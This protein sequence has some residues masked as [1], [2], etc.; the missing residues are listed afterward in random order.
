MSIRAGRFV[1]NGF[2]RCIFFCITTTLL[3]ACAD[4]PAK[5]T[6]SA[7]PA[8]AEKIQPF[9]VSSITP[10]S[11]A[12][13]EVLERI[14]EIQLL[15]GAESGKVLPELDRLEEIVK[16]DPSRREEYK[17]ILFYDL[18]IVSRIDGSK[19]SG[20]GNLIHTL[21]N[22]YLDEGDLEGAK[23]LF[24]KSLSICLEAVGENHECAGTSYYSIAYIESQLGDYEKSVAYYKRSI[25]IFSSLGGE[26]ADRTLMVK[27]YLA[28][29]YEG[30]NKYEDEISLLESCQ[31]VVEK[32]M[33]ASEEANKIASRLSIAYKHAEKY[34]KSLQL[35]HKYLWAIMNTRG[36]EN[37]EFA[38]G[39][40]SLAKIYIKLENYLLAESAIDDGLDIY[41]KLHL[42][43]SVDYANMLETKA[44]VYMHLGRHADSVAIFDKSIAIL[45]SQT[46][47]DLRYLS[48]VL[49]S[50]S[51]LHSWMGNYDRAMIMLRKSIAIREKNYP[52][53]KIFLFV[54]Q[55]NVAFIHLHKGEIDEAEKDFIET[56]A[57]MQSMVGSRGLLRRCQYGL[58][59]VNVKRGNS[60]LAILWGKESV[61]SI[62]QERSD[63]KLL[64]DFV[65]EDFA[66]E[67]RPAFQELS[68][69]L[70]ESGRLSE[71][72]VVLQMLKEDELYQIVRR[73]SVSDPRVTR[74]EL[75]L[76]EKSR[77][78][79]Y[80]KIQSQQAAVSDERASLLKKQKLKGLNASENKRLKLI[81]EK[82]QPDLRVATGEYL[83]ALG[84]GSEGPA[85]IGAV[86]GASV[87]AVIGGV[88]EERAF[89]T[90]SGSTQSQT[91]LQNALSRSGVGARVAALQYSLS[92]Q[93]LSVILSSP[94][95]AQI[96][97]QVKLDKNA[98]RQQIFN[99]RDQIGNPHTSPELVRQQLSKLYQ[100]LIA[101][102]SDDLD[103]LGAD[104]LVLLP[105]DVIRYVP[106]SA[107]YDGEKYLVEKYAITLF[108]EAVQKP[109]DKVSSDN[110]YLVALGSSRAVENLPALPSVQEEL[111]SITGVNGI[112]GDFYLNEAFTHGR[113]IDSLKSSY[114]VLHLA[115]HFKF[116]SGRPELSRFYLGDL[117][118]LT[119]DDIVRQ[120]LRFDRFKLVTFSA[121]DSALGGDAEGDKSDVDSLGAVVQMQ[122]A[123]S[124]M[125][126]LWKVDDVN[127]AELMKAFYGAM[128]H[129]RNGRA[130]ALRAAQL[131]FIKQAEGAQSKPY[132]WAPFVMMGDWL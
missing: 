94:G 118:T 4:N 81:D 95:R 87:G 17:R 24:E 40:N 29:A 12:E 1:K 97:R 102:L 82:L 98:L 77:L 34:D 30:S 73:A 128:G 26:C 74:I 86:L 67:N 109:L 130:Q 45:E 42:V 125:A 127:T 22:V 83:I 47:Q 93:R 112:S 115:S 126:A 61:N 84:K 23:I 129:K 49:N 6:S 19:G 110:W 37:V 71:A 46:P 20:V 65:Q 105:D 16:S 119:L 28:L 51:V 79:P 114:N 111:E 44:T 38:R 100:L 132:Y 7:A 99:L 32:N 123:Q 69:L 101:P 117:S 108:N 10:T 31:D 120:S 85:N 25:S 35:R 13:R 56:M 3:F 121:C 76:S 8:A 131:Q 91:R 107:L 55:I 18:L 116:V 106:F 53:D 122:G 90:K 88:T 96:S 33:G 48:T 92:D 39:L 104:T 15:H 63:L 52:N 11:S 59:Q 14:K 75:T 62:Q 70:I 57:N 68:E 113:F 5:N 124:V 54:N 21:A 80:Y 50:A 89:D 60:A 27:R 41:K 43:D 103:K 2:L 78:G 9:D 72:Q 66:S 64:P 36:E 58:F